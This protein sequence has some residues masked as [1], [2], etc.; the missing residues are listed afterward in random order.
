VRGS[1]AE[2][3]V[4]ARSG[5]RAAFGALVERHRSLLRGLVTRLVRDPGLVDD[6][7]QDAIVAA[8]TGL[9]RLR[10]PGSFGSWL[11][12]IG[13]NTGRRL[14]RRAGRE[15][16]LDELLG[17]VAGGPID[18]APAPELRSRSRSVRWSCRGRAATRRSRRCSRRPE[19][20][21]WR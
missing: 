20:G 4:R 13:L 16:P 12:G 19:R 14:L 8:L 10:E 21:C 6:V 1:D 3:V 5:D 7:V 17:G 9:D 2:L 15:C 18:P 11:A